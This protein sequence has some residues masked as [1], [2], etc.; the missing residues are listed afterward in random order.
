VWWTFYI[1]HLYLEQNKVLYSHQY[2]FRWNHSSTHALIHATEL[3]REACDS[4]KYA[5][6]VYLDLRKAFDT[7]NHEILFKK[8]KHYGIGGIE[9]N[10]FK[11]FLQGRTQSTKISSYFSSLLTVFY[12]VPQG[13]VLGPLLFII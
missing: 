9:N 13:S 10:W 4:G 7:V 8:L 1:L 6:T 12:G 5:S 2:G 3:I 11:S